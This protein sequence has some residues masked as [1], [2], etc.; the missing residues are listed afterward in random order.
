MDIGSKKCK[1][2]LQIGLWM[3]FTFYGTLYDTVTKI[4][5]Y[6]IPHSKS[7]SLRSWIPWI[8]LVMKPVVVRPLPDRLLVGLID[9][10]F[11][12][13]RKLVLNLL[14]IKLF[15]LNRSALY[16]TVLNS[17]GSVR[18]T[19]IKASKNDIGRA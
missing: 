12:T 10:T 6:H 15:L 3:D 17:A 19:F 11:Q 1:V 4:S 7:K 9:G 2:F 5:Q 13:R 16:H 18:I 14:L 8:R